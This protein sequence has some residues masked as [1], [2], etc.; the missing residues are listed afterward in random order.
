MGRVP[1][2]Q[3]QYREVMGKNPSSIAGDELPVINVSWEDAIRFCNALSERDGL[4][5]AYRVDG[6]EVHWDL[7]AEGYR[8]PTEAEWEYAARGHDGRIY[9]W[10][11]AP[12]SDQ[13]C[14]DGDDN[15]LGR[16]KRAGPSP[17]GMYPSGASPFGLLDMAGNVLEWCW[18][19]Y[20]PYRKMMDPE[21]N[22]TGPAQGEFRV[23]RGGSWFSMS[24]V[25][26]RAAD[27]EHHEPSWHGSRV[28]FR[29]ARGPGEP[30]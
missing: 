1:V 15:E 8:L 25:W 6:G 20:G 21:V 10:G 7:S 30:R 12:P 22:P 18:D 19:R 9:P 3:R 23:L 28:G 29:C 13:L 26:V 14:W 2:T 16:G 24:P 27:R 17:V 5:P 4:T 11:N